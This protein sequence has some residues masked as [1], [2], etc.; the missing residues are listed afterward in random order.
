MLQYWH[1]ASFFL[2]PVLFSVSEATSASGVV[3][4]YAFQV[5]KVPLRNSLPDSEICGFHAS[6]HLSTQSIGFPPQ[7][8]AHDVVLPFFI[9]WA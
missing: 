7:E 9:A 5:E 3:Y 2:L 6:V 8:L 1:F 4:S